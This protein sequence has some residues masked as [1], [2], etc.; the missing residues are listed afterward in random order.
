MKKLCS[1]VMGA[2]LALFAASTASAFDFDEVTPQEA[3]DEAVYEGAIILDVRTASEFIWVG[4]P[5]IENV[6]NISYKVDRKDEFVVNR[7]FICDVDK[8]FGAAP[9]T[10]IIT[11]CRSGKRSVDAAA[12][13]VDA[14]YTN[15]ASMLD[16]FQ[17]GLK[18]DFGYRT[19]TGWMNSELPGHTSKIGAGDYYILK[20]WKNSCDK[21]CK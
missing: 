1:L 14:G 7:A 17:G 2:T 4:H 18:D 5:N 12:A 6:V 11:M 15:V 21:G 13:L 19:G 9:D 8:L 16:G 3:Y 20:G 10:R